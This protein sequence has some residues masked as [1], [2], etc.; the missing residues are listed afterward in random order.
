MS[1]AVLYPR[2]SHPAIEERYASWQTQLL[3]RA[4][5]PGVRL[6]SYD[7]EEPISIAVASLQETEVAVVT[8]PL[9]L[10]PPD[11]IVRLRSV[12]D[13]S[14]PAVAAVPVTNVSAM[15]EQL[16]LPATA[17]LTLREL[18]ELALTRRREP[19]SRN[20]VTWRRADPAI[21]VCRRSFL[22]GVDETAAHALQGAQ[23]AIS[24]NDYIHRWSSLRGQ[25]RLDLLP[26]IASDARSILEFGCGES[27]LGAALKER[28]GARV[29]GIEIDPEAAAVARQRIDAVHCGDVRELVTTIDERF[30]A[31]IGGD[32]VE[33]LDDPWTFLGALRGLAARNGKLLLSLPNVSNASLIA[34]LLHGRFDYAYMG[35]TCVGHLRFFTR[36]TITE[37]LTIAGWTNV[38]ITPQDSIPTP[39]RDELLTALERGGYPFSRADVEPPGWYVQATNPG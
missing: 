21:Y 8:D 7:P 14:Q 3:L 4:G 12:L 38:E 2:Y 5:A 27:P 32:I 37:M 13:E 10:P 15:S 34:D 29:V 17:Y 16:R 1:L 39:G 23:V 28:Q 33:H 35:L 26:R 9:L 24:E 31:I 18:Q 36:T 22:D 20:I 19:S 6:V 30:E 11:L 25:I